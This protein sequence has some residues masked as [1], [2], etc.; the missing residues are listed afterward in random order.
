V[1][2]EWF[3]SS[4]AQFYSLS[5]RGLMELGPWLVATYNDPDAEEG[6]WKRIKECR[7]CRKL[8][9]VGQR[10]KNEECHCRL[11]DF[12]ADGLFGRQESRE[13]KCPVCQEEWAGLRFVG[14]RAARRDGP[15]N[16]SGRRT[17]GTRISTR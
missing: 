6:E 7:G 9:T 12:C 3:E 5:T 17:T 2:S 15:T 8:L 4:Q 13:R 14:E 10:C 1:E 11:H 16:L